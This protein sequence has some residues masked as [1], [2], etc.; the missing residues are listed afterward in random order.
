MK[1]EQNIFSSGIFQNYLVC[2]PAINCVKYFQS[3]NSIYSRKCNEMS[4]ESLENVTKLDSNFTLTF[5]DH[6]F[7]PDINCN[8]NCLIKNHIYISKTV[9]NL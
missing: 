9:I 1:T 4:G 6:H 3:T 2:L 7:L 5:V 8:V